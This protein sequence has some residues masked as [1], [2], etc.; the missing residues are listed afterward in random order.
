MAKHLSIC[1]AYHFLK[2]IIYLLI[3]FAVNQDVL[4]AQLTLPLLHLYKTAET[5]NKQ[6]QQCTHIFFI[7]ELRF[8]NALQRGIAIIEDKV[9]VFFC[10]A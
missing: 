8:K 5:G 4:K 3:S 2:F 10:I 1:L 6:Y 7:T 9:A